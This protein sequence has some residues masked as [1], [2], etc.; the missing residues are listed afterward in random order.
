MSLLIDNM[1]SG[2]D[3]GVLAIILVVVELKGH[4]IILVKIHRI[5][6]LCERIGQ[7]ELCCILQR[8]KLGLE[9]NKP[10]CVVRNVFFVVN[11]GVNALGLI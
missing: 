6:H 7:I 8:S 3:F 2:F 4:Y 10:I 1:L 11:D 9:V 5:L